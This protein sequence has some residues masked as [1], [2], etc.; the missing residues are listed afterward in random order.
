MPPLHD[1]N[2]PPAGFVA[3]P[4]K[5]SKWS[6]TFWADLAERVG[7]TAI[8]ALIGALSGAW[9]GV[10]PSDPAVWWSVVGV[11]TLFSLLKGL[12]ANMKNPESGPSLLP[13]PPAPE[14]PEAP[15]D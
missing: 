13:A 2:L 15:A 7:A 12:S 9:A 8:G 4:A 6:R 11:P 3:A 1:P 10:F 14:I 5:P